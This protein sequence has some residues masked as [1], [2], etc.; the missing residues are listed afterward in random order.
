MLMPVVVERDAWI[1][2]S[3]DIL[4]KL[5]SQAMVTFDKNGSNQHLQPTPR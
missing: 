3:A 2:P 5:D 1:S 4:E